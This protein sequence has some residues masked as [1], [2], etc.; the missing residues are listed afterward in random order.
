MIPVTA[1]EALQAALL[2]FSQ[3]F[4]EIQVGQDEAPILDLCHALYVRTEHYRRKATPTQQQTEPMAELGNL[5]HFLGLLSDK[6]ILQKVLTK[7]NQN[8]LKALMQGLKEMSLVEAGL[9][10]KD[11]A[12]F[13]RNSGDTDILIDRHREIDHATKKKD[14]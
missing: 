14:S 8:N 11:L 4:Q 7:D 9:R 6:G 5:L 12:G 10:K 3:S 2:Q 13:L 1:I